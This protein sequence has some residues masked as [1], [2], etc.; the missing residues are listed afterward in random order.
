MNT[1][2]VWVVGFFK[3]TDDYSKFIRV[4]KNNA[5]FYATLYDGEGLDA[6]IMNDDEFAELGKK[7]QEK[8]D[9]KN[10]LK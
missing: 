8:L 1:G 3:G 5:Q 2:H 7:E 6:Q 9:R 10:G 4:A